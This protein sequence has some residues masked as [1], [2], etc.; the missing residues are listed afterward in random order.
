MTKTTFKM[1]GK[2]ELCNGVLQCLVTLTFDLS[3]SKLQWL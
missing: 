2:S 1:P 3:A